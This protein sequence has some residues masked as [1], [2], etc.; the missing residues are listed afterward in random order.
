MRRTPDYYHLRNIMPFF[1]KKP[2]VIEAEQFLGFHDG[3]FMYWPIQKD[4]KG[5]YLIISTLE[6]D[7]RADDGDWIIRGIKDEYYPCKP[8]IF[9]AT[10]EP[11]ESSGSNGSTVS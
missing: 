2:I 5:A 7:H 8:D 1:R 11:V 4:S 3:M 10:Y 6:G 9:E